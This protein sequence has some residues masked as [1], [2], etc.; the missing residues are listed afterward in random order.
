MKQVI[1]EKHFAVDRIRFCLDAD[2]THEIIFR[3]LYGMTP[4]GRIVGGQ[5]CWGDDV[6]PTELIREMNPFKVFRVLRQLLIEYVSEIRPPYFLFS[7]DGEQRNRVYAR[8]AAR[9]EKSIPYRLVLS[10][11]GETG[12]WM[13]CRQENHDV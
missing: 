2:N 8:L 11:T 10:T 12:S 9:L 1:W 5:D 13:F 4:S 3:V 6:S 7:G